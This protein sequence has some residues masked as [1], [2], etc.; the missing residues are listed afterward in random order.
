MLSKH[1]GPHLSWNWK[2]SIRRK[3]VSEVRVENKNKKSLSVLKRLKNFQ[4]W[5]VCTCVFL[6]VSLSSYIQQ[7]QVLSQVIVHEKGCI[8]L[9]FN[10]FPFQKHNILEPKLNRRLNPYYTSAVYVKWHTESCPLIEKKQRIWS[11]ERKISNYI[12][13]ES[14]LHFFWVRQVTH[15]IIPFNRKKIKNLISGKKDFQWH[16]IP[17]KPAFGVN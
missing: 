11:A 17:L 7:H 3:R 13:I 14:I 16:Y 10:Q 12:K 2:K 4:V 15:G 8:S 6:E 5:Y 1:F 9:Q